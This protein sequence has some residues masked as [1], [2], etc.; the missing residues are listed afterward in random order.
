LNVRHPALSAQPTTKSST[1]GELVLS[2][3]P[4]ARGCPLGPLERA[5]LD[6]VDGR[7][8]IS[9][10]AI[11]LQL[12]V[13]EAASLAARLLELHAVRVDDPIELSDEDI[14]AN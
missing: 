7:R 12:G 8:T 9:D 11:H 4:E 10:L 5:L 3:R 2:V 14:E 6:M 1:T 13:V